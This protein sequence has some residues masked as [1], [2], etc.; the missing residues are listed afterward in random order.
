[1]RQM[2]AVN[3]LVIVFWILGSASVASHIGFSAFSCGVL[4][5]Y[6]LPFAVLAI[7]R[8]PPG[9]SPERYIV[10]T[11]FVLVLGFNLYIEARRFLP[12]YQPK[13]LEAVGYVFLPFFE[14]GLIGVF[15]LV[16]SVTALWSRKG[17]QA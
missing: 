6:S 16:G 9:R 1:M 15:V 10:L 12:G 3:K 5:G 4:V 2:F 7:L 8:I 14:L 13:A 17:P 11:A